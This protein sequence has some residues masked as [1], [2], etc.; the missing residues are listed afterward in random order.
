MEPLAHS[1]RPRRGIPAQSYADHVQGVEEVAYENV[2][3]AA[4]HWRGDREKFV[5][6]VRV[7]AKFHDLGKL[8]PANQA[9]LARDFRRE[10]LPVNHVDAGVAHLFSPAINNLLAATLVYAHHIGLP[11]FPDQSLNGPGRVL[12]DIKPDELGHTTKAITDQKLNDYLALHQEAVNSTICRQGNVSRGAPSPLSPLLFRIALS[13]LVDADHYDSARHEGD[14]TSRAGPPLRPDV[15]LAFLDQYVAGLPHEG[16]EERNVLRREVY[17]ACGNTDPRPGLYSCDSPVGTGKTTAVMAH[18]LHAAQ[19]KGLRR[20]FV[21][22]PFTNIIDQ[23]VEVYRRALV[24]PGESH[25]D[26][27]A[28]HHHKAEF[29]NLESRHLSFLWKAPIVVTTAVQFFETLAAHRTGSLRKLH[30]LPGSAI[31]VDEAHAALPAHLWPQAWKWLRELES[32]W[33]C[34]FVLGSGSLNRFWELEEFSEDRM[35]LPDLIPPAVKTDVARYEEQR[36]KYKAKSDL[37]SQHDLLQWLW[38][39]PGPRLLIVNTVQS[40]AVLAASIAEG[41]G[42]KH[43]EHLSTSLC[44]R[45]RKVTLDRVKERLRV[46]ADN[47]WTLVATSCVE[48]GVNLSFHNGLRERCSLNSLIQVGGRVNR[49]GEYTDSKVWDFELEH[50]G[51]LKAHPAFEASGRILGELFRDENVGSEASTE[52]MRRE[53]RQEGLRDISDLIMK[54]ERNLRFPT[55]AENFT[56]IDSNT[57]TVIVEQELIGS[58]ERYERVDPDMLQRMSVQIWRYKEVDYALRPVAGFRDL[59]SWTLLYDDFLGYMAGVLQKLSH[60]QHGTIA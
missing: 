37:L 38:E 56:V 50:D 1:P 18:L 40:A 2:R 8:E 51:F 35:H 36:I 47:D 4:H 53:V 22:L 6:S 5:E 23:S 27:V 7:A 30:Q 3:V 29:E 58:L 32:F 14:N 57:V 59:Y 10:A 39:I 48:A 43:V 33:G 42:R 17:K 13:C 11:D 21:V 28:A 55:V 24:C 54:A 49:E 9:V 60:E 41:A 45:D 16:Q 34:H 52:A 26:V 31:F 20:V 19:V 15:R 46:R 12:R 44:P 25:E